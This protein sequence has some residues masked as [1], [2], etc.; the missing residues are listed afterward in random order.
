MSD[1]TPRPDETPSD[2]TAPP[3]D[4][5]WQPPPPP[6]EQPAYQQPQPAYQQ[7]QSAQQ[8]LPPAYAGATP[9]TTVAPPNPMSPTDERTWGMLSHVIAVGAMLLSGGFLGFVGALVVYLI[10]K[11]RGPFVRAHSANSLNVQIAAC[12]GFVIGWLLTITVIGAIIGI[13]I[14]IAVFVW[15]VV[16]H[17]IGAV[18]ANNG[19][20]W[21]PPMTPQFVK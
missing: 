18:K 21:N 13:P 3:A 15:A 14:L 17:V 9:G 7:P 10:Y 20:W 11:D 19:E 16:V 2:P 5:A 12:I 8:Q 1:T 4:S 6:A